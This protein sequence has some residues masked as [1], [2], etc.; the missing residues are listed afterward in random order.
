M[1]RSL[2]AA[3]GLNEGFAVS[4]NSPDLIKK[5]R[6]GWNIFLIG[7]MSDLSKSSDPK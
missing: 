1:L 3:F 6:D 5:L 7:S 4:R 2:F